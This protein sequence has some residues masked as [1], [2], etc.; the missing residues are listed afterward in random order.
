MWAE[1]TVANRNDMRIRAI[2]LLASSLLTLSSACKPSRGTLIAVIPETTAQE[3][4]ES[5]H[6]GAERAARAYGWNIYW[7]GPSREDDFPRQIH[8]VYEAI[9]R[10]VAGLVLSP[11]H[12]VALISPVRSALAHGIPTVIV[13]SP[14]GTSPGGNLVFVINDDAA[15]GRLAAERACLYLNSNDAVA[16]L[17]VDPNILGSIES[18]DA[19]EASLRERFPKV[20]IIERR[21]ISF[22][23]AEAEESVEQTIRSVPELRVLVTLNI[24]QTRAARRAL[25]ESKTEKKIMLIGCDQDLDLMLYLRLGQIDSVIAQNTREMGYEAVQIIHQRLLGESTEPK[26]VVKPILVTKQNID[27]AEVQEVLD[28][29][30]RGQ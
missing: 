23:E 10:N 7:N 25:H 22:S 11:D 9:D 29:D 24:D 14:L 15:T 4:S 8:L 5:E 21:S 6:A 16:V 2:F 27:S 1:F 17:G 18:A 13:G 19:F 12:A 26:I 28:M 20:R 30:W 3:L